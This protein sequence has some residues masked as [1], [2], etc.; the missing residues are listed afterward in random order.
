MLY[1]ACAKNALRMDKISLLLVKNIIV[2]DVLIS[3]LIYL[4]M[5]IT[6]VAGRWVLGAG[7]CYVCAFFIN[8]ILFHQQMMVICMLSVFRLWMLKQPRAVRENIPL[9]WVKVALLIAFVFCVGQWVI[10]ELY[11]DGGNRNNTAYYDPWSFNC[12]SS[13]WEE[14]N[15]DIFNL[16]IETVYQGIPL[17]IV[18]VSNTGTLFAIL[19][20]NW[21][22]RKSAKSKSSHTAVIT[23]LLVCWAFVLS[24][25]PDYI[26]VLLDLFGNEYPNWF[27]TIQMYSYALNTIINPLIYSWK[28]PGFKKFLRGLFGIERMMSLR[29]NYL[30]TNSNSAYQVDEL[31]QVIQEIGLENKIKND[32]TQEDFIQ[33]DIVIENGNVECQDTSNNKSNVK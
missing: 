11:S 15:A 12:W 6:L 27:Y 5:M 33:A 16:I 4:P 28:D 17:L 32:G 14:D 30:T 13:Q 31:H 18:V 2:L 21:K 25:I 26:I 3:G 24:Y 23:L 20:Q 19:R 22:M 7:V 8:H 10:L 1:A 9:C 29:Q